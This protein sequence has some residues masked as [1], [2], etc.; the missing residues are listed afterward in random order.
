MYAVGPL[1]ASLSRLKELNVFRRLLSTDLSV[2][3]QICSGHKV[4]V[5][6]LAVPGGLACRMLRMGSGGT[7]GKSLSH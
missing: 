4:T 6:R 2:C 3:W 5:Q 7:L 1:T